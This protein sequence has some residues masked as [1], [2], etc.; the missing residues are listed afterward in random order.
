MATWTQENIAVLLDLY[1]EK[2]CLYNTMHN[3][4]YNTRAAAIKTPQISSVFVLSA[5][6]INNNYKQLSML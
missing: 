6:F 3:T 5:I 4:M 1:E 2:P